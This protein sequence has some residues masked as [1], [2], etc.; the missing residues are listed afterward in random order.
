VTV[1]VTGSEALSTS[2]PMSRLPDLDLATAVVY[3]RYTPE[4]QITVEVKFG[5][6]SDCYV[7]DDGRATLAIVLVEDKEPYAH[8]TTFPE[9]QVLVQELDSEG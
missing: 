4:L 6:P 9:C 7:N 1:S 2:I 3:G 8:V 5:E